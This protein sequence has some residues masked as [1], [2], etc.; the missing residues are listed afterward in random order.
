[1][2]DKVYVVTCYDAKSHD[3]GFDSSSAVFGVFESRETAIYHVRSF[4]GIGEGTLVDEWH[5]DTRDVFYECSARGTETTFRQYVITP[6]QLIKD[7]PTK[8]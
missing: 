1:M 6:R 5:C 2:C 7:A 3:L 4:I 8:E